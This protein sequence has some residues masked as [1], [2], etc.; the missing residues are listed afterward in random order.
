MI[1]SKHGTWNMLG[2]SKGYAFYVAANLVRDANGQRHP[3]TAAGAYDTY[4][5]AAQ[6]RAP[7]DETECTSWNHVISFEAPHVHVAA[8]CAELTK[9]IEEW[10]D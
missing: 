3:I 8:R 2:M 9:M 7:I 5:R 6:C 4:V 10:A 1:E